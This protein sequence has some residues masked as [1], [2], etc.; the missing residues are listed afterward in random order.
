[1]VKKGVNIRFLHGAQI[2]GPGQSTEA[3]VRP[4]ADKTD[5]G[6]MSRGPGPVK[7]EQQP[8]QGPEK[9]YNI[10]YSSTFV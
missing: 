5:L 2:S 4:C 1:M 3:Q 9:S 8:A 10:L 7:Y 6:P